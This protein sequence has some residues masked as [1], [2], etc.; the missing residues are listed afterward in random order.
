MHRLLH[1]FCFPFGLRVKIFTTNCFRTKKSIALSPF[2]TLVLYSYSI[3]DFVKFSFFKTLRSSFTKF[4]HRMIIC[5][6]GTVMTDIVV[7]K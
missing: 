6:L 2:A 5:N 1:G 7:L 3:L 4:P